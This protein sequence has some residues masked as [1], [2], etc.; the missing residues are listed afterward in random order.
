MQCHAI[1]LGTTGYKCGYM[2]ESYETFVCEEIDKTSILLSI[3]VLQFRA[4][5]MK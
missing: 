4:F 5:K 3:N 1:A 2:Y